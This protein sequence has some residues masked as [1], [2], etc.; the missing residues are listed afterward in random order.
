M[1]RSRV[2]FAAATVPLALA[3]A[4][5]SGGS[6]ST[7]ASDSASSAASTS[8]GETAEAPES[9]PTDDQSGSASGDEL[10]AEDL[11]KVL[12]GSSA[13]SQ[14]V[15]YTMAIEAPDTDGTVTLKGAMDPSVDPL[16][17]QF[18]MKVR[19]QKMELRV[20]DNKMYMSVEPK[21]WMEIPYDPKDLTEQDPTAQ[22]ETFAH[23][24]DTA[25][26]KGEET[27]NGEHV[28]HYSATLDPKDKNVAELGADA[29]MEIYLDDEDRVTFFELNAKTTHM[30]FDL[31]DFGKPV[32]VKAPPASQL[33]SQ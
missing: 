15:A 20:V 29:S 1:R 3:V 9:E 25:T 4:G 16:I 21:T 6:D 5:C 8:D 30:T 32:V 10:S 13:A 24:V 14:P 2:L 18:S 11:A 19:G 33:I 23:G 31:Y 7:S 26:F 17:M 12:G 28:R 27:L 22:M